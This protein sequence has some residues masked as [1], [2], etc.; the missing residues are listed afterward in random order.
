MLEG[1]DDA[2][3]FSS[4]VVSLES[5]VACGNKRILQEAFDRG[6]VEDRKRI[7]FIADCGYDVPAG[8]IR[9]GPGLVL[10]RH[11]DRETDL[12]QA[13]VIRATVLRAIPRARASDA[14]AAAITSD[15]FA[16]AIELAEVTGRLRYIAATEQIPLSF[17]A[18]K[19]RRFRRKADGHIDRT[20]AIEAVRQRSSGASLDAQE[21]AALFDNCPS[22]LE[23][24]HGKDM[25]QAVRTVIHQDYGVSLR[26]LEFIPELFRSIDDSVFES[27][28]V[29]ARIRRWETET[30]VRL[31]G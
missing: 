8:R 1:R 10:T 15:V 7:I 12:A 5:I 6:V 24:C 13:G 11:T 27:W 26:D 28:E 21:L 14:A 9:P 31:L 25:I 30:G 18:L 29:V 4:R 22:G 3:V 2:V 17:E 20:A 16:K 23:V 19:L